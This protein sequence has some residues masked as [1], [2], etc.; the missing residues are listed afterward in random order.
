M[1]DRPAKM[2][3]TSSDADLAFDDKYSRLMGA[4]GKD[5]LRDLQSAHILISGMKG[6]GLEI[7]TD[8]LPFAIFDLQ[9]FAK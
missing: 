4:I 2:L 7:G 1:S 5:A 8:G 3:K 9:L 6:L